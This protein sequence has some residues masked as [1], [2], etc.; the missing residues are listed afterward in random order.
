[1]SSF[2]I[3]TLLPHLSKSF[4]PTSVTR[5]GRQGA[6]KQN[7][8]KPKTCVSHGESLRVQE[9]LFV[10]IVTRYRLR[11][12]AGSETLLPHAHRQR[13]SRRLQRAAAIEGKTKSTRELG[14]QQVVRPRVGHLLAGEGQICHLK[15]L[16][17][18]PQ[19][20]TSPHPFPRKRNKHNPHGPS[21]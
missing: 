9:P 1:M 21:N 3:P 20:P 16:H 13:V 8:T 5:L 12:C 7:Q 4:L 10:P 15:T 18:T 17:T 14:A 19:K 6:E 2:K 11:A